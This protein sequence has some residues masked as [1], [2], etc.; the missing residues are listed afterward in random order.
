MDT[1]PKDTI[2]VELD[3][4]DQLIFT[5]IPAPEEGEEV[6]GQLGLPQR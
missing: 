1:S 5:R 4:E 6:E 3:D 2:K